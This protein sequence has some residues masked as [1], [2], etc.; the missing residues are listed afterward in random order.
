MERHN[1][2]YVAGFTTYAM[3]T[4]GPFADLTDEEFEE[5][6]LMKRQNCSAT[7]VSSGPVPSSYD[8]NGSA[9]V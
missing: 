7:H 9:L 1:A 5:L 6:Y 4:A 8:E 2:A 3:S